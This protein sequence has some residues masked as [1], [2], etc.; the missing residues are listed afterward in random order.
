MSEAKPAAPAHAPAAPSGGGGGIKALLPLILTVSL[1]PVLAY[2][3]TAFVMVPKLQK[4]TVQA[5]AEGDHAEHGAEAEDGHGDGDA[6]AAA[7]DAGSKKEDE[8]GKKEDPHAKKEEAH[9]KKDDGHG[10]KSGGSSKPNV[11]FGKVLVN[12]AGSLGARYLLT[13]FTLVG[14]DAGIKDQVEDKKDQLMDAALSAL[15][16]KTIQDLERPGAANV[17]RTELLSVFNAILGKGAVKEIFFTE[18]AIQ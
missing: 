5:R 11:Q 2:V 14:K 15:R 16:T 1:M 6:H 10:G 7:E 12:V 18:F 8:H 4:A 17:I 9:G 3:M 13:N